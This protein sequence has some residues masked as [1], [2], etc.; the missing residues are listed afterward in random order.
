MSFGLKLNLRLGI[1]GQRSVTGVQPWTPAEL[2][3]LALW[4]DADDAN[5]ITLNGSTVS[6]WDDKSGNANHVSNATASTQPD[7]LATGWNGQPTVSFTKSGL[8]FLFKQNVA[9][10]SASGDF[11]IASAFEFLETTN[12]WDMIAGWRSTANTASG[13]GAPIL[14]GMR[15]NQEIGFHNTDKVD[16]RI[17]VN[18]TTRLGK[19]IATISRSGGTAGNNG[20]ATVTSTGFSQTTYQTDATQTW[21]SDPATGFQIGGRQQGATDYGDKYISEVVCCNTK[22]STIDRQ[23][24]EG[25]LAWKWGLE[26]DLPADHPYKSAP[27]TVVTPSYDPDAQAYFNRVE[28]LAGDNQTLETAVKDAI[29]AFVV[30]CKADGIWTAIK[31]SA[32][33]A[34]A[35]TLSGALQPLAGTAPTNFN[36]VSGD[37]N[38]KTGLKGDGNTKYLDSGR[39]NGADPQ[40]NRHLAAFPSLVN[41]VPA[42]S[43]CGGSGPTTNQ[44]ME[45]LTQSTG[46]LFRCLNNSFPTQGNNTTSSGQLIGMSRN[47]SA[48]FSARVNSTTGGYGIVSNAVGDNNVL[49]FATNNA[50]QTGISPANFG[51]HRIAFYSIG[52]ALDLAALD[53]RAS[54]LMTA[55]GAAIP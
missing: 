18:V 4:L 39:N 30:G 50:G 8:E 7:Y 29:N 40:N 11:T 43:F 54:N 3:G 45:I 5:T 37:Y 25:Y 10:F 49:I 35:R 1:E 38:R 9:N 2:T 22:L 27:P 32:I 15:T 23:K 31:S 46:H 17:K 55:I 16:T 24:L 52:E 14:Q 21:G 13:A 47:A 34:G 53:T 12:N 51:A 19:K 28:G 33:L 41:P 36:F 48:S 42:Q 20:A 44:R 26:A 6:Q